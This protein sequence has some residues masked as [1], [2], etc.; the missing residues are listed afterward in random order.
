MTSL[1]SALDLINNDLNTQYGE[2]N[3]K[4][5]NWS[6]VQ[7]EKIL[8]L[9]FQLLR[10]K[11]ANKTKMLAVK[12]CDS[13]V[14]GT[15]EE[16]KILIKLLAHTR[17]I[18]E[19]KGEY[20]IS[21]SI[22]KELY[23]IDET[24]CNE[25]IKRFVGFHDNVT[26][27]DF[28]E[29]PYGSWKDMKYLFNEFKKCPSELINIINMQLK[30]DVESMHKN[31]SCSLLA[32]WIPREKSKKF[33]W[34]HE[35]L[36]MNY[37]TSYG[38]KKWTTNA[39]RK[40]Q[41]HYRQLVSSVNKYLGTVQINQ[42]QHN[43]KSIDFNRV[44]SIT[45]IKQKS[46]FLN[47]NNSDE[48]DRHICKE[49][50]LSYMS[51]VKNGKVIMKGGRTS[52]IDFVKQALY[53]KDENTRDIINEM[54]KNN[55]S[56]TKSLEKM[57]AM[58][59]TSGSMEMDNCVPLYSAIGLGIRVAEKSKLGKRVLTFSNTPSWIN[60][61]EKNCKNFVDQVNTIR[62]AEWGSNTN[63]YKAMELILTQIIKH[64]LSAEEVEELVLVVFSDMQFDVS[65]KNNNDTVRNILAEKF[66]EAGVKV[67]GK[68]YKVP[69][70]LFWNLRT[71]SGFPELSYQRDVTMLSGYSPNLLNSFVDDGMRSLSDIT[72]WYMLNKMLDNPRYNI[73]EN[74]V[75]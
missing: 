61:D 58:V 54:W 51:D 33:G 7:Q 74:Y 30:K 71:T 63:F 2:N 55:S 72:P 26:T 52:I 19:G 67:C 46:A 22:V 23:K 69:H 29:K 32:K 15:L 14:N 25:L 56:L 53:C 73:L 41:T 47:S 6:N 42:C 36:A 10:N 48:E 4:E 57:I 11:D 5:Y 35:K 3:H 66:Y 49:N 59:D 9:S 20:A 43:W 62:M 50:L 21:F 1:V 39:I 8:Q 31:R 16:K 45:M 24:M 13:Y 68:G 27:G 12:F 38:E 70:I 60:I 28:L 37:F 64:K 18:E 65:A 34:I 44:T 17:D 40:A 75:S